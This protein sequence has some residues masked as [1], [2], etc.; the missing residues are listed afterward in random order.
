MAVKPIL[1]APHPVL[2]RKANRV[3][4]LDA[5]VVRLVR[6]MFET[7]QS[8]E[9]VGLAA[10]QIGVSLRV[11]VIQMPDEQPFAVINPEVVR[12]CGE[13]EV[14]EGCLSVPGYQGRVKRAET[15]TVKGIDEQGRALRIKGEELLA[16]ALEHEID[17][18][19]GVLYVDLLESPDKLEKIGQPVTALEPA[20]DDC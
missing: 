8:A 17:H 18:L 12:R 15:V 14:L 20:N 5:S 7:L 13:R 2:R 6:D 10:P 3:S 1:T 16:Q 4:A 19:N 11:I 9:G